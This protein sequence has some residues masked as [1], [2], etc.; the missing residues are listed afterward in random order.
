MFF[1]CP[2]YLMSWQIVWFC[3]WRSRL[4]TY[5]IRYR[6][7]QWFLSMW[8][9]ILFWRCNFSIHFK[10]IERLIQ[11]TQRLVGV[12]QV[13]IWEER[14]DVLDPSVI[15]KSL[16]AVSN[17]QLHPIATFLCLLIENGPWITYMNMMF[18]ESLPANPRRVFFSSTNVR[19][20]P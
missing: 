13:N 11:Q 8:Y 5:Y 6:K 19:E 18:V 20:K 10:S 4:I 2:G 14:E 1:W 12:L 3:P 15:E 16:P 9:L 17:C 7:V